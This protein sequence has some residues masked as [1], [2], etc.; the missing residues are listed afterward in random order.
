M[1]LDPNISILAGQAPRSVVGESFGNALLN[2]GRVQ[3]IQR[4]RELAPLQNQLLQQKI[5]AG[6]QGI[7]QQALRQRLGQLGELGRN[8]SQ[9]L[10]NNDPTAATRALLRFR[11]TVDPNDILTLQQVDEDLADVQN[12]PQKLITEGN[13]AFQLAQQAGVFGELTPAKQEPGFTL[14]QG[15]QRF[16][17]QG[18]RIASV[19]PKSTDGLSGLPAEAVAFN[20][21]IKDF[22][23]EQQKT[24]KLVKAGLKGRAISNAVLSAIESGDVTNLAEAKAE[25]KQAEKF[26]ELT[27]SS[28]AKAIDKGFDSIIKISRSIK[29]IDDA[30]SALDKGAGVGAVERIWP[31]IRA[32]SVELDN[33]RGRM[34]LDVVG[35]TTFGALSKGELDLA[36]D[37]ALPTG[38]NTEELKAFLIEK[39]AAQTKLMAYYNEQIQFIDQGGTVAGFL[40]EKERQEG[41]TATNP[42]TGEKVVFSNGQ[43]QPA[44]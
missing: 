20:D 22:T 6:E 25:I 34:A 40:R 27:G 16:D 10:T 24:A 37:V 28:R 21:L 33:V 42:Q 8:V 1:A 13:Q 14:G 3:D 30:I 4:Q 43:W 15:Q 5:T 19:A 44:P 23:P 26:A 39:R 2:I 35:A 17:A 38:L 31:S 12:N 36:K 18:R 32:A 29:N 9:S 11:E 41:A 7:A